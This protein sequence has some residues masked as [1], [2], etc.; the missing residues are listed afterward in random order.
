MKD[1]ELQFD[2]KRHAIYTPKAKALIQTLL[3]RDY[4]PPEAEA[5][6][7]QI[8]L[9]YVA[10]LKDEPALGGLKLSAGVYDSILVFAYYVTVPKKPALEDIQQDVFSI[11]MGGFETLGKFFDLNR[12]FDLKL[13]GRIFGLAM[14][15]KAKESVKFPASF[16]VGE[17]SVDSK[18]GIIRYS[19]SQCPNA[20]FAKRH[21][22]EHVLPLMCNCDHMTMS[23]LHAGLIRRGTCVTGDACDYCILG[24]QNPL[25]KKYRLVSDENGL[26]LS[27]PVS[28]EAESPV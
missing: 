3:A 28:G 24:D 2:R 12:P 8:Q 18:E 1:S 7:E 11:F 6:W 13:A 15:T 25:L 17:F 23:Q 27:R 9:Q 20:E 4:A 21:G 19:F 5:L 22:L 26:W 16:H 10:Y 14:K